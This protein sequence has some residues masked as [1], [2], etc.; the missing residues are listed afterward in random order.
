[1][2]QTAQYTPSP[3]RRSDSRTWDSPDAISKARSGLA[4]NGGRPEASGSGTWVLSGIVEIHSSGGRP[5]LSSNLSVTSTWLNESG[6]EGVGGR[7]V[8][9]RMA[10][11]CPDCGA[12]ASTSTDP[13]IGSAD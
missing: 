10:A 4:S 8:L 3:D 13:R 6:V 5:M 11:S 1:M 12:P 9:N 7:L 2:W